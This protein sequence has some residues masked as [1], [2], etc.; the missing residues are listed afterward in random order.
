M[1]PKP[2]KGWALTTLCEKPIKIG[3]EAVA[4]AKYVT[5]QLAE[6]AVALQL[7]AA[8]LTRIG[9][10]RLAWVLGRGP[11]LWTK[12]CGRRPPAF[13]VRRAGGLLGLSAG[14]ASGAVGS[15]GAKATT[16]NFFSRATRRNRT[17]G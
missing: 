12:R 3:A 13:V 17:C 8:F 9:R 14:E 10:L 7:F 1:L 5:S 11:P 16:G 15:G 2:I 6:V 4:H